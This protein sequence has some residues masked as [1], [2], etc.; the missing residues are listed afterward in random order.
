MHF[1]MSRNEFLYEHDVIGISS[2]IS[3]LLEGQ[4]KNNNEEK[5]GEVPATDFL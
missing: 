5:Y 2:M 1:N 4:N 3:K